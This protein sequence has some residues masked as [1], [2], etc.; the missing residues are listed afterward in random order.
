MPILCYLQNWIFCPITS[1]QVVRFKKIPSQIGVIFSGWS[2]WVPTML[3]YLQNWAF[4][5]ISP[6]WAVKFEKNSFTN[7]GSFFF[8]MIVLC[9]NN[10]MFS[11]KLNICP[12]FLF[13]LVLFALCLHKPYF[14]LFKCNFDSLEWQFGTYSFYIDLETSLK[15]KLICVPTYYYWSITFS[16][17]Y[18]V[19]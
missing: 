10:P 17:V 2:L 12:I 5:P 14:L 3:C 4:C 6:F 9:T 11:S 1:F 13:I 8:Q 15:M 18:S 7:R 16:A 19:C